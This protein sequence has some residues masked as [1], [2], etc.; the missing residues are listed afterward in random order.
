M[1][2]MAPGIFTFSSKSRVKSSKRLSN[3]L[4]IVIQNKIHKSSKFLKQLPEEF[5]YEIIQLNH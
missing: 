5:F 3:D 1:V 2:R 4:Q